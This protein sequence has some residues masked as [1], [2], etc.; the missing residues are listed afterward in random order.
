MQIQHWDGLPDA[1]APYV[2]AAVP[3]K[4]VSFETRKRGLM[5]YIPKALGAH[6]H[7]LGQIRTGS[8]YQGYRCQEK[9]N[10]AY[11]CWD[12]EQ[13]WSKT[14]GRIEPPD[15][16]V[17]YLPPG[18]PLVGE[19]FLGNGHHER[20]FAA[21]LAQGK[22]P[23]E[24][25]L[26]VGVNRRVIWKHA[27]IVAF[28][29]P[30]IVDDWPYAARHQLLCVVVGV[31]SK[32]KNERM[33]QESAAELP[34]QVII[35]YPMDQLPAL[36]VEIIHGVP[37]HQR[38][39]PPFGM[40]TFTD[41][42]GAVGWRTPNPYPRMETG[43][44]GEGC[45]LWHQD[46]R[47]H[48]RGTTGSTTAILK[49]KPLFLTTGTVGS[50]GVQHSQHRQLLKRTLRDGDDLPAA[51]DEPDLPGYHVT[52][53]THVSGDQQTIKAYVSASHTMEGLRQKFRP[54]ARVF[55]V[56]FMFE[57][58]P[59]YPRALGP[60]LLLEQAQQVQRWN[61]HLFEEMP[62]PPAS[63][64]VVGGREGAMEGPPWTRCV[65]RT[66]GT[67]RAA[68]RCFPS[69]SNG[70]RASTCRVREPPT[71]RSASSPRTPS[72]WAPRPRWRRRGIAA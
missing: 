53:H 2:T 29:V 15:A 63:S 69:T 13:L 36:F 6:Y 40:P 41:I 71:A 46:E 23:S 65:G 7:I 34:V 14:G 19:L 10:G 62:I 72:G 8:V 49:F 11:V 37:H 27:R 1:A 64:L 18:F 59:M 12:G 22:L 42:R 32:R 30:G 56:F 26:G 57:R 50:E 44:P 5:W 38:K 16:F 28:D 61:F 33:Y 25:T 58:L 24:E 48:G 20:S 31:W 67:A 54:G 3:T 21:T 35:Q 51:A 55:F 45:M 47:W 52:L 9:L 17:Q 4:R 66:A 68:V 43:V 60:E 70:T 39:H